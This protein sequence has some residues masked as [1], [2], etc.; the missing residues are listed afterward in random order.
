MR[1]DGKRAAIAADYKT[2]T[3]IFANYMGKV[4]T[5]RKMLAGY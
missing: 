2:Q 5:A 3:D 1:D 4:L